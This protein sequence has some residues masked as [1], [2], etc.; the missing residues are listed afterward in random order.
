MLT[1]ISI[2][3]NGFVAEFSAW[4]IV[5]S[6]AFNAL[7]VYGL[8]RGSKAT[9]VLLLVL[10][11]V[12]VLILIGLAITGTTEP[13]GMMSIAI[14]APLR[15]VEFFVLLHPLTRSWV[16]QQPD[17]GSSSER[18]RKLAYPEEQHPVNR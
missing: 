16:Q 1:L 12:S 11:G 14:N 3:G 7:L 2:V 15:V 17:P 4:R 10:Q 8:L 5:G 13:N 18:L 9:W 6:L